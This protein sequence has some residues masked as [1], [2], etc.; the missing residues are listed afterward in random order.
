[1]TWFLQPW[2][3]DTIT[4]YLNIDQHQEQREVGLLCKRDNAHAP[5]DNMVILESCD[6]QVAGGAG[7]AG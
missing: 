1:M 3:D 2:C 4:L 6:I 7:S 5:S